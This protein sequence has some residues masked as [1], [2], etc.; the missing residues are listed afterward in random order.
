MTRQ[1]V[2]WLADLE[3]PLASPISADLAG[4]PPLLVQTG[5][6]DYCREDC[7]RFAARATAHGVT[8]QLE[9]WPEMIHV[10]QRFAPKLPEA[11]QALAQIAGFFDTHAAAARAA[12]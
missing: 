4:L 8:A 6:A 7:E 5:T 2:A 1:Y 10:W 9:V 3:N 12:D 11:L